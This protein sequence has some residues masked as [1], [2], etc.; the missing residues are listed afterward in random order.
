MH[1]IPIQP[2]VCST[3]HG[4]AFMKRRA[5]RFI[6]VELMYAVWYGVC[7]DVDNSSILFHAQALALDCGVCVCVRGNYSR[8]SRVHSCLFTHSTEKKL[9]IIVALNIIKILIVVRIVVGIVVITCDGA[10]LRLEG[11]KSGRRRQVHA[12]SIC[13]FTFGNRVA[14]WSATVSACD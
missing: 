9:F 1:S 4:V 12:P 7:D 13:S 6:G 3:P 8:L 11:I 14:K 5:I 10:V 2:L